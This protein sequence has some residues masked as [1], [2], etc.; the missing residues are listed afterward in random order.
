M[1]NPLTL[2]NSI[3]FGMKNGL[4]T[5]KALKALNEAEFEVRQ[6]IGFQISNRYVGDDG[7]LCTEQW[8]PITIGIYNIW[9]E[10][11]SFQ[12]G[13]RPTRDELLSLLEAEID[14][15]NAWVEIDVPKLVF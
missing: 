4:R 8:N 1:I 9:E 12:Y 2:F 13:Y 15:P 7:I 10:W 5:S 3:L 14:Q 11:G 6:N